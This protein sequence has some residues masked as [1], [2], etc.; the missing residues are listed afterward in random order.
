MSSEVIDAA[1]A[2]HTDWPAPGTT[3]HKMSEIDLPRMS[4]GTEWWYYNFHLSL[5]D[6]RKASAFIALF[7][8]TSLKPT[9]APNLHID[10]GVQRD[11]ELCNSHLLN[12]AICLAPTDSG[13]APPTNPWGPAPKREEDASKGQYLFTSAMDANNA[14]YMRS[15]LEVDKQLDPRIRNSLLQVMSDG[16]VPEPD[17]IISGDISV[18]LE[19]RLDLKYGDL[20]SVVCRTNDKGEDVYH[21]IAHAEDGSYGFE[22]DLTPRKPPISHGAN[23]V[24]QGDLVTPDDGMYY[25]FVPRCDVSGSV[26]LDNSNIE[27]DKENSLGWYDREFGGGIRRWYEVNTKTTESSW[28]WASAQLSNG[29]D[30]T[31][32]T[33]WDIDFN[34]G[35][36]TVRD[37]RAIAISPEGTRIECDEHTLDPVRTWTSMNTLN[38]YGTKWHLTVP[39]LKLD[40]SV[41]APFTKQEFR[42]ICAQRGYWEGRVE[43]VGTMG[44][45]HVTGLG[46]V[47]V[48]SVFSYT[49][50]TCIDFCAHRMYLGNLSRSLRH[51]SSALLA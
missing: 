17:I 30:L 31:V 27:V 4:S 6:G 8:T 44:G 12:F 13:E 41:E 26:R 35:E 22:L 10:D 40:V 32:Y 23:G 24:V 50:P 21:I 25:C 51:T 46:F 48:R 37:K 3:I 45:D 36:V 7:R 16:K 20:A 9:T 33:L 38:D 49:T 18:S 1:I 28:K 34:S 11:V 2:H 15:M 14:G 42:T 47:E 19:G 43:I 5:V 39:E 29:W